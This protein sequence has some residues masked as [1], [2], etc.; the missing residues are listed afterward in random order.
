MKK[1]W[2][3]QSKR[4]LEDMNPEERLERGEKGKSSRYDMRQGKTRH[5]TGCVGQTVIDKRCHVILKKEIHT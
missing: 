5:K 1:K 2:R 3:Q 4:N